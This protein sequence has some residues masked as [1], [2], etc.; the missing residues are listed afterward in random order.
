MSTHDGAEAIIDLAAITRNVEQLR[1]HA[2][3]A[4]VMTVV[5]A[6]GY[7]HGAIPVARAARDG[8]AQWLGVAT[9]GEAFQLRKAGDAGKMLAWLTALNSDFASA[10]TH[11]IQVSASS[12][13]ILDAIAAAARRV[14]ARAS[15]HLATDSGLGREGAPLGEQWQHLVDAARAAQD[16][17]HIDVVGVWSHMAFA[18]SPRHPTIDAQRTAFLCAVDV[19]N[20][21]GL[22]IRWRHLANSAATLTRPD[23]HFDLVRPGLAVYG[24]SPVWQEVSAAS[25]GLAPAMTLQAPVIGVKRLPANHGVGYGHTYHTTKE[26]TVVLISAGYADGLPRLA[27]NCGLVQMKDA[28]FTLAG[29]V[30]MDQV[31]VDVGDADI[32]IGDM[33][34]FFGPGNHGEPT[35]DEWADAVGTISYEIMTRLGA[36]AHKTYVNG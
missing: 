24:V 27:S 23:L 20:E 17:G 12:P 2:G 6:D 34:T 33:A 7:G 35:I 11:D 25:L 4:E 19:A 16:A 36:R 31:T 28:R 1:A 29:R 10:I 15:I 18:D 5:K 14:G 22:N 30:S 21:A 8:G 26:T 32:R 13:Q 9:L 3:A